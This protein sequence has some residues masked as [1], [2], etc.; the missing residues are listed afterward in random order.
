[1]KKESPKSSYPRCKECKS[2]LTYFASKTNE[3]KCRTCGHIEK[4]GDK[5]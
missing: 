5:K 1:M 3:R 2:T 4:L